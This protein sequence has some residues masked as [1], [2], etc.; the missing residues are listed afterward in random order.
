VETSELRIGNLIQT[1]DGKV[2][3]VTG[4][5]IHEGVEGFFK[6]I[7]LTEK[8]LYILGFGNYL[9]GSFL[10]EEISAIIGLDGKIGFYLNDF[11]EQTSYWLQNIKYVHQLQNIYFALN[12]EELEIKTIDI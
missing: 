11:H 6:G 1:N 10:L 8:Y 2:I 3:K 12:N 9:D 4:Q 7:P 5:V